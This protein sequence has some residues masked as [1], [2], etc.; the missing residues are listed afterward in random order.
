M[1]GR[2]MMNPRMKTSKMFT[3]EDSTANCPGLPSGML[4]VRA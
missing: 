3:D 4:R 1:L 2:D